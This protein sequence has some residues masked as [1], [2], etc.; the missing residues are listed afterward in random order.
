MWKRL[1]LVAAVGLACG[2]AGWQLHARLFPA[3]PEE[4][5]DSSPYRTFQTRRR[6][7]LVD[8]QWYPLVTSTRAKLVRFFPPEL[9]RGEIAHVNADGTVLVTS[10]TEAGK[11]SHWEA[12][13]N[14]GWPPNVPD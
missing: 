2:V 4:Q 12:N 11:R 9:S 6:E 3:P 13:G 1:A 14:C 10:H 7:V 5:P 8:G